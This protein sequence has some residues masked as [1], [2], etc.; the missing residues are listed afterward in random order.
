[1][2][3]GRARR[4]APSSSL[5][6]MRSA[7]KTRVAGWITRLPRTVRLATG[8]PAPAMHTACESLDPEAVSRFHDV[9]RASLPQQTYVSLSAVLWCR[10]TRS[11]LPEGLHAAA[12]LRRLSREGAP[13]A[14]TS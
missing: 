3:A 12:F 4:R 8:S 9:F 2:A 6:A 13:I 14:A 7:W 1:M 11:A 5:T 10:S